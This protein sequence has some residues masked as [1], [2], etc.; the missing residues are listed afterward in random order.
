MWLQNKRRKNQPTESEPA[1]FF[2][3]LHKISKHS[4]LSEC[5][6]THQS[7]PSWAVRSTSNWA[8]W[9]RPSI[10][11]RL[12]QRLG[13]TP[14][15]PIHSIPPWW[16][17]MALHDIL[18][19]RRRRYDRTPTNQLSI[20]VIRQLRITLSIPPKEPSYGFL[21]RKLWE[22]QNIRMLQRGNTPAITVPNQLSKPLYCI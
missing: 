7:K 9:T 16:H 12:G 8:T 6:R 1:N 18:R 5:N 10:K 21:P 2:C 22:G 13:L 4:T 3:L 11:T 19:T 15:I 14:K 20:R 17:Y